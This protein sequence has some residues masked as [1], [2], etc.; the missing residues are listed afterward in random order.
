MFLFE[1]QA[2]RQVMT[3]FFRVVGNTTFVARP[4]RASAL[5][6]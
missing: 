2:N 5:M 6:K 3:G 4:R 1:A